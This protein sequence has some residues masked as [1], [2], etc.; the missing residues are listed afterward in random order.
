MDWP[1]DPS[2]YPTYLRPR[3]RRGFGL[4]EG[5]AYQPWIRVR[6]FGSKGTCSNFKGVKIRR[7]FHFLSSL[8]ATNY[9]LLE[10]DPDVLDIR[11]QYPILDLKSTLQ[12]CAQ[13]KIKHGKRSGFPEPF[14]ID[15]MVTRR[16]AYGTSIQAQSIKSAADRRLPKVQ[17]RLNIEYQWCK[18]VGVPWA[19]VETEDFTKQLLRN[20]RFIRRW[21][22][23]RYDPNEESA[24]RFADAFARSY[25]L[26]TPLTELI[27]MAGSRCCYRH[28]A[29]NLFQYCAWTNLLKVDLRRPISLNHSVVLHL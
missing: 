27:R 10:R 19:C 16:E 28:T 26:G 17:E 29:E 5:A 4:G 14:T 24:Q 9:L 23:D 22:V 25:Q 11:E 21:F 13:H 18:E 1:H 8:E 15:F 7:P 6:D 2:L 12:L 3:V 20:L